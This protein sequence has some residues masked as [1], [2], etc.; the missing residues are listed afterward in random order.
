MSF[1]VLIAV[2]NSFTKLTANRIRFLAMKK[3]MID[4]NPS[5]RWLHRLVLGVVSYSNNSNSLQHTLYTGC[6]PSHIMA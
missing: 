5:H 2:Y 6:M 4:I 1:I 3:I